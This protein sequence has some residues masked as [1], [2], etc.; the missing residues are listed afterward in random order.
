MHFNDSIMEWF[1]DLG[2]YLI[3]DVSA[4]CFSIDLIRKGE[5]ALPE[6]MLNYQMKIK[7]KIKIKIKSVQM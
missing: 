2:R 4:K 6:R 1:A 7:I 3:L 5:Y